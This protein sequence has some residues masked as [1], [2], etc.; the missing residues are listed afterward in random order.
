[1]CVICFVKALVHVFK[2]YLTASYTYTFRSWPVAFR[3]DDVRAAGGSSSHR[4]LTCAAAAAGVWLLRDEALGG[5]AL[6]RPPRGVRS[7]AQCLLQQLRGLPG[8]LASYALAHSLGRWLVY[9][10]S[11]SLM[12]RVLLPLLQHGQERLVER[13]HGRRAKLVACDGNEIDT[14]FMDRRQDPGSH[15]HGLRLVICCEGNA[16]FYEMGCLSAPLEAG[17]SVLGWNHPGFGG[18]TGVPSPQ[19]DANAMDVVVQYA[20]HCLHFSPAH[21]VVYGWSVGGFTATWATMT[22]PGLGALVLDATF[23]DL[24]PLALKVMPHSWKGLVVRTVREHFNLNV[25]EQLCCYP[26]PVLLLRR[27][28]DDVVSTSGRLRPLSPGGV[29]GNRGNELLLRLL[30]HRYPA[31]M[32]PEGRSV[33]IRWLRAGSLA[34]EAAF[35]ARCRVD[36][37][38][39]LAL[40]RS[41]R[42]R[43]EEGLQG[44]EAQGPHG[45]AFPW[46][47]GQGLS[48]RRRRRL[49]LFLA[50]KHLKNVEA[51]HFSPLEPEEFQLPWGL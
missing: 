16:G 3:W 23:D 17:Y 36:E 19:H 27:T 49:A 21:V 37:K 4:A 10:G 8:H 22:Y 39:C 43:C 28:Q 48:S 26:G 18:S 33:V 50:R 31:V 41:Y 38:W 29:E 9:P 13:Y 14:M 24:V 1:M 47:V 32:A 2:I 44:E 34:Q 7:Q 42:A 15:G 20:L 12:R 30:E 11:L 6:G 25:A 40:L 35:Y 51:T 45:P 5:D 46:L